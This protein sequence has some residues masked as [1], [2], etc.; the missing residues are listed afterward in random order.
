MPGIRLAA[1]KEQQGLLTFF[2]MKGKS[3]A[4]A[5]NSPVE[6]TIVIIRISTNRIGFNVIW[7]QFD[8]SV[9]VSDGLVI[10]K[11]EEVG[12][13]T[14]EKGLGEPRVAFYA[15]SRSGRA[16]SRSAMPLSGSPKATY[17]MPRNR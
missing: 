8:D 16:R 14:I 13:P 7:I 6:F 9:E 17:V 4:V 10:V 3:L 1:I 15:R 11:L 5:G 12:G 2:K